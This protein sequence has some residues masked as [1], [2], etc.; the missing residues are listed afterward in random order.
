[1]VTPLKKL[2]VALALGSSVLLS[3]PAAF[4]RHHHSC[5]SDYGYPAYNQGWNNSAYYD[6]GWSGSP[7][8]GQGWYGQPRYYY[9]RYEDSWRWNGS[10]AG[11][12]GWHRH[13][14]RGRAWGWYR[15]HHHDDDD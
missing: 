10:D 15:H 7:Y 8:Y 12:R 14:P 11:Y 13:Q 9:P 6:R 2:A 4:A 1:M 3:A 5:P